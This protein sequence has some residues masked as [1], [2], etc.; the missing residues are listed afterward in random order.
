MD[1]TE[2]IP[3]RLSEDPTFVSRLSYKAREIPIGIEELSRG[4]SAI[5]SEAALF[6][7]SNIWDLSFGSTLWP[8]LLSRDGPAYVIPSVRLE[9][10]S[11]IKRHPRFV[12]SIAVSERK[13][14][15]QLLDVPQDP[16]EAAAYVYY[17]SLLQQ[18]R[19]AFALFAARF[20]EIEGRV[21]T[22]GEVVEGVQRIYGQRTLS[23]VRKHGGTRTVDKWA[24]DESL[25]YL[26]ALH[27]LTTGEPTIVLTQD[28]D[29][30]EQFYKLWWFL[31]THYRAMLLA[32]EYVRDPLKYRHYPIPNTAVVRDFFESDECFLLD[33]GSG[34]MRE[35]LPPTFSFVSQECWL[36]GR[37][38][39]RMVFGAERGMRRLLDVKGR[40]GGLVS[41]DLQGR[42]LHAYLGATMLERIDPKIVQNCVAVANDKSVEMGDG[43]ARLAFL[44][45]TYALFSNERFT[46]L[47]PE[48]KAESNPLGFWLPKRANSNV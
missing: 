35:V 28:Q 39:T 46:R 47:T 11:W 5:P 20:E 10:D 44:D 1:G 9:L 13:D 43:A 3:A 41:A 48:E 14:P 42:N 18:R 16:N 24:T 36:L 32:Q 27:G 21:P 33:R 12:G 26:A 2:A 23:L 37:K 7:D 15:I 6:L 4:I 25:V 40:T 38:L 22:D 45:I 19:F 31:D 17:V 34:R 29:V 8:A 30:L